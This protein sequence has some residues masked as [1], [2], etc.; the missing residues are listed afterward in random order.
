MAINKVG[1]IAYFKINNIQYALRGNMKYSAALFEREVVTGMDGIHGFKESFKAPY[2]EC[3]VT[4]RGNLSTELLNQLT[5]ATITVE[6][7][8][9]KIFTLNNAACLTQIEVDAMEGQFTIRF[10]GLSAK[11]VLNNG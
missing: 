9:G 7:N 6:L 3:D 2:L 8:N 5:D 10:E 1:G 11:E 4:D